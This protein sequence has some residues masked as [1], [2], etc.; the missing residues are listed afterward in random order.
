MPL[1]NQY[2][3]LVTLLV[4]LCVHILTFNEIFLQT[5]NLRVIHTIRLQQNKNLIIIL[6]HLSFTTH[7]NSLG[8][9]LNNQESILVMLV[10]SLIYN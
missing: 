8:W 9:D 3:V 7:L 5:T 10:E 6:H 2:L 1:Y 4:E